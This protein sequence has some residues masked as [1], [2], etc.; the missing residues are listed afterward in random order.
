MTSLCQAVKRMYLGKRT[1]NI[2]KNNKLQKNCI[3]HRLTIYKFIL[4]RVI[5]PGALNGEDGCEESC[6]VSAQY[7]VNYNNEV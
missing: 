7:I 3:N 5:S 2:K 6:A 1:E 4:D